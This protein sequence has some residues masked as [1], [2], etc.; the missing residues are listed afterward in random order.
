M[1]KMARKTEDVDSRQEIFT[2]RVINK[3]SIGNRIKGFFVLQPGEDPAKDSEIKALKLTNWSKKQLIKEKS[4]FIY[5]VN[6]KALAQNSFFEMS[7]KDLERKN[8]KTSNTDETVETKTYAVKFG[9]M[10]IVPNSQPIIIP[11]EETRS[12]KIDIPSLELSGS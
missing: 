7:T 6:E 4:L 3:S 2:G 5:C 11:A 1:T 12:Y 8:T 10:I 9:I